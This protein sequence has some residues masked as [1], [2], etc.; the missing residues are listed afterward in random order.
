[1][2]SSSGV[3]IWDIVFEIM[4]NFYVRITMCRAWKEK[5][6]AKTLI[7]GDVVK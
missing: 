1:M 4:S 5:Q 6:M 3:K 7:E 2:T